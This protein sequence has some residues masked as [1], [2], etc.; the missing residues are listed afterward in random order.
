MKKL[1][2]TEITLLSILFVSLLFSGCSSK[3]YFEPENTY[4]AAGAVSSYGGVIVDQSRDGAT[5]KSGN[6]ISKSGISKINLGEGY[7]FLSESSTYVLATNKRG[8]LKIIRRAN[9][10]TLRVVDMK[11]PLVS[12]SIK[13]G[14]VAYILNDNTFGLYRISTDKKI[15]ENKSEITYAIDTRS[16]SPMFIDNLAVLPML[17]G[18]L[19]VVDINNP[20]NATVIYLSSESAFNNVIYLSRSGNTMVAATQKKLITIGPEGQEELRSNIS[21]VSISNGFIYLFSKEGEVIKLDKALN[22]K[23]KKKFKF[24][25]FSAATVTGGKVYGLD[26]KGSLVVLNSNLT[27]S[28]IYD[29]GE[30]DSPVFISGSK[31]YKD[32][33]IIHLTK[34]GYE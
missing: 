11:I 19:I 22:E 32:G 34:L 25:H 27:K 12:A 20:D 14:I 21:D 4:D 31:L 3:K 13:S 24:L 10:S 5:L 23:A 28:K 2:R 9:G 16:A 1:L 30:V 17:D 29:V 33:K 8:S 6:Y 15:I 7:R 26:Q 18:K